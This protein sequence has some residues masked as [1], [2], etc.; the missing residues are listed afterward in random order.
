MYILQSWYCSSTIFA[1][2]IEDLSTLHHDLDSCSCCQL[3]PN[4]HKLSDP[5]LYQTTVQ[6]EVYLKIFN[7]NRIKSYVKLETLSNIFQCNIMNCFN[8]FGELNLKFLNQ[9]LMYLSD[10]NY[11]KVMIFPGLVYLKSLIFNIYLL[12]VRL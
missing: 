9:I 5:N 12:L 3:G 4:T 1:Q 7:F 11:P 10:T 8:I 6:Q 2:Q